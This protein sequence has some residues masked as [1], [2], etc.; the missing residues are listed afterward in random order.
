MSAGGMSEEWD[1]RTRVGEARRE[2]GIMQ[3][4]LAQRVGVRRETISRIERG[5]SGGISV[6]LALKIAQVLETKVEDIFFLNDED[7]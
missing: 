1:F 7:A 4:E 3:E 5:T 2:K 6:V